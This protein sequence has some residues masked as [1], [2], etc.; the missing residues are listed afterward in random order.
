[1]ASGVPT[2]APNAGG[3]LSYATNENAWL[4]EPTGQAFADAALEIVDNT[5]LREQKVN[6]ALETARANTR[7]ASTDRLLAT[8]DKL[9]EDFQKRRDLFTNIEAAK[10]FDYAR[11]VR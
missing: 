9:Y 6:K 7:E 8:F 10:K 1:M 3:I 5:E 4:V 2:L 11:L